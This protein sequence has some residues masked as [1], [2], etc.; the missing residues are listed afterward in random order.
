MSVVWHDLECGA[1]AQDLGLWRALAERHGDPVLEVGAGTGRVSLELARA[2]HRV[3][4][5]DRD[6]RLLAELNRRAEGLPVR[7]VVADGRGFRLAEQFPLI[8]V[9]MQTIQ[10]LGGQPGRRRFL[11]S[12]ARH[13]RPGGVVA[14]AITETLETFS[15]EDGFDPPVPDVREIEG[16]VYSSQPTSV[17]AEAEGFVLERLRERVSPEGRRTT[18]WDRIH[19]DGLTAGELEREAAAVGLRPA[20][21]EAVSPTD[22]Y[23][24]SVVVMLGG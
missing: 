17:R 14:A 15:L 22:D 3:T 24:G 16:F 2:G 11:L 18:A 8:I 6:P 21:R 13:L 4:A 19:L 12:A 10:L 9:P 1:Y 5:L 23:V 20:G 7:T